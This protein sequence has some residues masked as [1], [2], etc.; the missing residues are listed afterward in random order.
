M[1][2]SSRTTGSYIR[3]FSRHVAEGRQEV[4]DEVGLDFWDVLMEATV[5]FEEVELVVGLG[6][7]K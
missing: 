6:G 3:I 2:K 5:V 1:V 4:E 7:V